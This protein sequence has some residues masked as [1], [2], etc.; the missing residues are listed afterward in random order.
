MAAAVGVVVV[1]SGVAIVVVGVVGFALSVVVGGLRDV[2]VVVLVIAIGERGLKTF[3][4]AGAAGGGGIVIIIVL[5]SGLLAEITISVGKVFVSLVVVETL[6]SASA[7]STTGDGG[8]TR[9][10]W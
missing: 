9:Q 1:G 6:S 10:S 2:D 4:T 8:T 7:P 3:V 5:S